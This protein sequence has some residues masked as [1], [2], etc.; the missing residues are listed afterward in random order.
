MGVFVRDR[1]PTRDITCV[2]EARSLSGVAG[3][4]WSQTLTTSGEGD[5]TLMFD[6]PGL[7]IP[8]YGPYVVTCQ[9]PP[10]VNNVPS[11]ISAYGVIE[12]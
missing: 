6:P 8:D 7:P 1:H 5:Q 11:Y 4:G 2:A 10:M 12:P 9:L 3:Q